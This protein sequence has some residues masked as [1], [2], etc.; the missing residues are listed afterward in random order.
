M[1][2]GMGV[3]RWPPSEFWSAALID[4]M[5]GAEGYMESHGSGS[6]DPGPATQS[7]LSSL[8]AQFPDN[9]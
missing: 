9:P 5:A 4:V 6:N 2:I 3:L 7:D 1:Q 8:M